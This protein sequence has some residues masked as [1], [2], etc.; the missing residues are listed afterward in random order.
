MFPFF[1]TNCACIVGL[2]VC[3]QFSYLRDNWFCLF[4]TRPNEK[5]ITRNLK[6]NYFSIAAITQST[7]AKM[8][9]DAFPSPPIN[10]NHSFRFVPLLSLRTI[11]RNSVILWRI[12]VFGQFFFVPPT[13]Q[14][15]SDEKINWHSPWMDRVPWRNRN[16]RHNAWA[17]ETMSAGCNACSASEREFVEIM[18]GDA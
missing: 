7:A 5:K 3:P 6:F 9:Y 18:T 15:A 13:L 8:H 17:L 4:E 2:C 12:A 14:F 11:N 10:R 1:A 16:G